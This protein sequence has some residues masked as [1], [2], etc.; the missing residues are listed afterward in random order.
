MRRTR[1]IAK[2]ETDEGPHGLVSAKCFAE[3]GQKTCPELGRRICPAYELEILGD[4][5]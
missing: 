4:I 5:H 1:Q 2:T 3:A